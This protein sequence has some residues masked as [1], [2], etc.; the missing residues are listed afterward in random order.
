MISCAVAQSGHYH[1]TGLRKFLVVV[2]D[3]VVVLFVE[4]VDI[5]L[6]VTVQADLFHV[7]PFVQPRTD[8][9]LLP[10]DRIGFLNDLS[11]DVSIHRDADRRTV[12]PRNAFS[13]IVSDPPAVARMA[14]HV[15]RRTGRGLRVVL[16]QHPIVSVQVHVVFQVAVRHAVFG[17]F[18]DFLLRM[19][20]TEMTLAAVFRLAGSPRREIVP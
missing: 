6:S 8:G 16:T 15:T 3:K 9:Q 13:R 10:F 20:G 17:F 2:H 1:L 7:L 5:V 18:V 4:R 14:R 19:V 11:V 12:R